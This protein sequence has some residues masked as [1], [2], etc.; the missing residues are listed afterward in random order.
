[1]GLLS[2]CPAGRVAA[3][4]PL[5][6]AIV[7]RSYGSPDFLR[8]E[9]IEKT[10]AAADEVLVKVRAASVN[11]L[12]WRL[13][14]GEPY[15]IRVATGLRKPKSA[16]VGADVAGE[17]EAVG[18]NVRQ[19][20]RGDSVFGAIGTSPGAFAEYV[21]AKEDALVL[22][23][24][25]LTFEQAAAVPVAALTA[26]QGLRQGGFRLGRQFWSTVRPEGSVHSQ[27]RSLN[28]WAHT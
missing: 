7:L 18:S 4:E 23:P 10:T 19:F 2:Y 9:D 24:V 15:V 22:K 12:D 11:P 16:R 3:G 25:N 28:R 20:R 17:V 26:L 13:V 21:C 14:R 27:C 8:Y 5:M 6:K 1:M